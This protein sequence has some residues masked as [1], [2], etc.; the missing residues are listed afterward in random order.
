MLMEQFHLQLLGHQ[1]LF[2]W[3]DMI[4]GRAPLCITGHL[5]ALLAG[6]SDTCVLLRLF[7]S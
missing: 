1:S 4:V 2:V 7:F 3:P 6:L 5:A